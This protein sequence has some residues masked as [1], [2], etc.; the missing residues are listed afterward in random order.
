MVLLLMVKG[1]KSLAES[2]VD[3]P[4]EQYLRNRHH[5]RQQAAAAAM[6]HKFALPA[7]AMVAIVKW[8]KEQ[9]IQNEPR[10]QK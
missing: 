2:P 9:I 1:P 4:L 6:G 7:G 10:R 5:C 8:N 3:P